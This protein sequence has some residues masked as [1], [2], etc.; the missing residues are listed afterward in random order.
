[1][2]LCSNITK[3]CFFWILR[4][5]NE[6][7]LFCFISICI[8]SFWSH[9][10]DR[11]SFAGLYAVYDKDYS[12][13]RSKINIFSPFR[14]M[15]HLF[16]FE[17]LFFFFKYFTFIIIDLMNPAVDACACTL[18]CS[19]I[20]LRSFINITLLYAFRVRVVIWWKENAS[21]KNVRATTFK[22]QLNPFKLKLF[23]SF[24]NE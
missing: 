12:E 7:I 3:K 2:F 23:L 22:V 24:K 13:L 10:I 11:N 20:C 8:I 14:L 1:M 9:A 16:D 6:N 15:K 21:V 4:R 5:S 18:S 17:I 19:K